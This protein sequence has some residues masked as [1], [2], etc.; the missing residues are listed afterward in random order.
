MKQKVF[1]VILLAIF[2]STSGFSQ[3]FLEKVKN[4]ASDAGS[5]LIVK[6]SKEKA[7]K[8]IDGTENKKEKNNESSQAS[9]A[10]GQAV[11][12]GSK[13]ADK[14]IA[15]YSK[16]D[17]VP[18]EN[19]VFYENFDQ[20]VIGEFPLK[21]FTNGSAEVVTL[22]GMEGKWLKLVAGKILSP[23]VQ[24]PTN[25]TLEYDLILDMPFDPNSNNIAAFPNWEFKMY[26]GGDKNLKLSYNDP[27]LN[28]MLS[29]TT[30]FYQKYADVKLEGVENKKTKI[31][32]V[33]DPS[34]LNGFNKNYNGGLVH[35][36]ITVQGERLRI[37]Y[38]EEKAVDIP[39]AV[40]INHN[41]N[42][43]EFAAMKRAGEPAFYVGN[44]KFSEGKSDTRSK[45][46][47]EG[48]LVTTGIQFDSGSDKIK[49]VSYGILKEIALAVRDN[50][51]KI[52]IIGHTDNV[53][54]NESNLSLS[55]RRAEAVKNILV[56]DFQIDPSNIRTDGEG[57]SRPVGDNATNIGKAQ[58]RRVEFIKE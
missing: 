20:D 41:F 22:E 9:S 7:E 49:P 58:N 35:V 39:V 10:N 12:E 18:G 14:G 36:A 29:V 43:I 37:W 48:K 46:M 33:L 55:K 17:F 38:N 23:T 16:F 27:K 32:T 28:N 47:D 21:W 54:N 3:S 26:D 24:L 40:A 51:L 30:S 8:T 50:S 19:I 31:E 11:T 6:K 44:I 34:R 52:K 1:N 45:L 15:S 42:Q 57:A 5:D 4:K 2:L 13:T 53:G 56:T 25:F